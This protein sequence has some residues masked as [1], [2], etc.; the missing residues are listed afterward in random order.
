MT[1]DPALGDEDYCYLTTTGRVTGRL[2]RI[3]IW[4]GTNPDTA[5]IYI[6][7]GGRLNADFVRNAIKQPGV[8]VKIASKEFSGTVRIVDPGDEDALA[9]R[10]LLEKYAPPRYEGD[11]DDWGRT[12]LTVAVDLAT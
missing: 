9:R 8:R 5:T 6:L 3:E 1:L 7:A 4:F 12:A 11:L 2:H 10:L